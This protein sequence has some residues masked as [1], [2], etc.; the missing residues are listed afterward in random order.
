MAEPGRVLGVPVWPY[1]A[2]LAG[3]LLM[4]MFGSLF[5]LSSIVEAHPLTQFG[6][7]GVNTPAVKADWY[8]IWMYGL[9]EIMPASLSFN[10]LGASIEPNFM[11]GI[12]FPGLLFTL[13][14]LVP[15]IDRTNRKAIRRFEYPE[16]P[17]QSACA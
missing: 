2:L 14:A 12:V 11:G 3:Q 7:P 1:Q 13:I 5:I 15:L 10:F 8:L 9:L 16:P 17:R 6:P 4:L